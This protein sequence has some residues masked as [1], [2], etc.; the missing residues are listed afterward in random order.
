MPNTIETNMR[1]M[2]FS[3]ILARLKTITRANGYQTQPCVTDDDRLARVDRDVPYI[4]VSS[5]DEEVRSARVRAAW[6]M[7]YDVVIQGWLP[8]SGLDPEEELAKAIQDYRTCICTYLDDLVTAMGRGGE[9]FFGTMKSS[10]GS[11]T[12]AGWATFEQTLTII[13][14]NG[15]TW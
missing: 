5:G 12:D 9:I 6:T 8:T 14:N 4:L 1:W 7:G 11:V 10:Q 3:L 15:T 2:I 13:Y